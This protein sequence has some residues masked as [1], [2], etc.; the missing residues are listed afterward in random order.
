MRARDPMPTPV[1]TGYRST[2]IA[3]AAA[4]LTRSD[5]TALPVLDDDDRPVGIVSRHDL[6]RTQV[7]RDETLAADAHG[8]LDAT[9]VR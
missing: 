1:R 3:E 2:T 5:I 7:Q 4:L 8:R 9:S 6:P